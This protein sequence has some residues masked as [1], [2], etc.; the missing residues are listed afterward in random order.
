MSGVAGFAAGLIHPLLAPAHLMSLIDL[1]LLAGPAP[2]RMRAAILAAFAAG[3]G[4]GLGAI[5]W[6]VGETPANDLLLAAAAVCGILAAA[7]LPVPAWFATLLAL[8]FG[9]A[10]G[11]DSPPETIFIREAV[12][13]LIGT[14]CGGIAAL[15]LVTAAVAAFSRLWQAIPLRVVGSWIAAIAILVLALRLAG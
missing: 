3:L 12:L 9:I 7:G 1:G 15:A 14:A 11:L 6:G 8:L 2:P 10:I 5:A 13:M 4:G